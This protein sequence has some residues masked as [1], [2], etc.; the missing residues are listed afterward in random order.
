[1]SPHTSPQR[2]VTHWGDLTATQALRRF[3]EEVAAPAIGFSYRPQDARWFRLATG[4]TPTGSDGGP[5]D[6][7][8]VFEL[9]AFTVELELRWR[10]HSGGVGA[11][12]VVEDAPGA[13]PTS[14]HRLLWGAPVEWRDGWV[15][16]ADARIG[17]FTVPVDAPQPSHHTRIWLR[18]V[19]YSSEDE[20]GN[21]AVIDERLV[22][23]VAAVPGQKEP[24]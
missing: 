15:T 7:T 13:A 10:N 5:F 1:M 14:Y 11:A 3:T 20:H 22:A 17:T 18:A 9:R 8:G 19:E 23:L 12:I 6:L 21:V 16:L 24:A 4:G 2:R